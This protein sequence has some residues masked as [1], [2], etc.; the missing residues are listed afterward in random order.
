MKIDLIPKIIFFVKIKSP[1]D[2]FKQPKN[3]NIERPAQ[4]IPAPSMAIPG[5]TLNLT[6]V[7]TAEKMQPI[8]PIIR[9]ASTDHRANISDQTV[10]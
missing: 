5:I 9:E 10:T 8:A 3:K 1:F 7:T 6:I 2:I 4:V